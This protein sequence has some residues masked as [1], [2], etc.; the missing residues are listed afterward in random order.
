MNSAVDS[1]AYP[2]WRELPDHILGT[3]FG[4]LC[5]QDRYNA[6]LVCHSWSHG[7]SSPE[8]WRRFTIDV[9]RMRKYRHKNRKKC[10]Q[11]TGSLPLN[12]LIVIA[13]R[14]R[15]LEV[16]C[17]WANDDKYGSKGVSHRLS[18]ALGDLRYRGCQLHTLSLN[19]FDRITS[20]RDS[21]AR[22]R[23][24][25]A[26][27]RFINSQRNLVAL[28]LSNNRFYPRELLMLIRAATYCSATSVT[29]INLQASYCDTRFP[30]EEDQPFHHDH[31]NVHPNRI[32]NEGMARRN[33][34]LENQ[35]DQGLRRNWPMNLGILLSRFTCLRY[36]HLL[37][38]IS[39]LQMDLF[40]NLPST[41]RLLTL[42]AHRSEL[43][44]EEFNNVLNGNPLCDNNKWSTITKRCPQIGIAIY[45]RS[46]VWYYPIYCILHE[47]VPLRKI[48]IFTPRNLNNSL[49]IIGICHHILDLNSN[50]LEDVCIL[51][52]FPLDDVL[53]KFFKN[54][55]CL[56][57]LNIQ[58]KLKNPEIIQDFFWALSRGKIRVSQV[59]LI[60]ETS[61]K[62][63]FQQFN[64]IKSDLMNS[65]IEEEDMI[66]KGIYGTRWWMKDKPIQ[67][68]KFCVLR[69]P[70]N[71]YKRK[72]TH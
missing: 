49:E 70:R 36:L 23:V 51:V 11:S 4:Y 61:T 65:L 40:T 59:Q 35:E 43:E 5:E 14:V 38:N 34:F 53:P 16:I 45:T 46:I 24:M 30:I 50:T 22:L 10:Y 52:R 54:C 48:H 66:G 37:L 55:R 31:F 69:N 1:K 12:M 64:S 62:A 2:D 7:F 21:K 32:N 29:S 56:K 67:T 26:L 6:S 15:F 68:I 58:C 57:Y 42:H 3:I 20:W 25:K 44:F 63:H 72:Q 9:T 17:P 27:K 47:N 8:S 33:F 41:F 60:I 13:R 71:G 39:M 19:N 18:S 28:D